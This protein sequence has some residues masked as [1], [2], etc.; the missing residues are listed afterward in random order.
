MFRDLITALDTA[1]A[2]AP[3]QLSRPHGPEDALAGLVSD[4]LQDVD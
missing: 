3:E 2:Q 1:E 4:Q